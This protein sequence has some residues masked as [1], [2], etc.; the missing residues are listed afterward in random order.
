M[1]TPKKEA[2]VAE[3][4]DRFSRAQ[5][6][7]LAQFR[8]LDVRALTELRRQSREAGVEFRVL[9]NTLVTLAANRAG[10]EGLEDHLTG[11]NAYAFGYDDPVAPAKVLSEFAKVH[12]ELLIKAG[13]LEGRVIDAQA[14]EA[15]AALPSREVL[16]AQLLQVMQGPISG[17]VNVL[18]GTLGSLV[19]A[20]EAV[21][22][23]KEQEANA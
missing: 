6:T 7:V 20:L 1:P 2:K 21:R 22:Q 8:G 15:L 5:G 10:I 4:Q 3:I 19:Y 17:L 13:V 18:Q 9:K 12:Q 11:P 14:V 23:K 16:L